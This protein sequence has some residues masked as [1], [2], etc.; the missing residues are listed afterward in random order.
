MYCLTVWTHLQ[1]DWY[2]QLTNRMKVCPVVPGSSLAK[3]LGP[4]CSQSI[5][6]K[7]RPPEASEPL[8]GS[9]SPLHMPHALFRQEK[10]SWTCTSTWLGKFQG[11]PYKVE[12]DQ[13]VPPINTTCRPVLTHQQ[14][15]INQIFAE[16][17]AA[18]V[19]ISVDHATAWKKSFA[20][21]N[22]YS[23][24]SVA[25]HGCTYT[26]INPTLITL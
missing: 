22:K 7:R 2:C 6:G 18:S 24:T 8:L 21:V 5:S 14:I 12:I 19:L 17:Q 10:S 16:M 3:L 15:S 4:M 25:N 23:L 1:L 20:I 11:E 13:S 9:H 26:W